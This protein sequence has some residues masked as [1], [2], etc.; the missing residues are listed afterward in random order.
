MKENNLRFIAGKRAY[1]RIKGEGLKQESVSVLAGA[2]GGPKWLILSGM[3]RVLAESFF[4]GRKKNLSTIGSSIGCWRFA[5]LAHENPG[6]AFDLFEEN[7]I[8]QR[9]KKGHGAEDVTRQSLDI[10]KKFLGEKG[11]KSILNHNIYRMNIITVRC[12]WPVSSEKRALLMP[13]LGAGFIFNLL[14]RKFNSILFKRTLFHDPRKNPPLKA[15]RGG[16]LTVNLTAENLVDSLIATA[17]IP[18]VMKG[19]NNPEGAPGGVYRDGGVV[20]YHLDLPFSDE[21][22][23][24]YPHFIPGIIPGWFDK[25]IGWRKGS[26]SNMENVLIVCPSESFMAKLPLGKIPDRNDFFL[27]R[28][29]DNERIAYWKKVVEFNR[30]L[31]EEFM[32]AVESGSLRTR[33]EKYTVK[34]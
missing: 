9:Y 17:S 11:V 6:N 3:D 13:G 33:I 5:A 15:S 23:V 8:Y 28:G 19:V 2:A 27:F 29:R 7:Y 1:E 12:R 20:D 21:G 30:L 26:E 16:A 18:L 14:N 34:K 32:E 22:L 10:L 25:S 31:G 4:R 24:L